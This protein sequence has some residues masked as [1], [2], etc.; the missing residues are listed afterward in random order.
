MSFLRNHK[1]IFIIT[2]IVTLVL[3]CFVA[4]AYHFFMDYHVNTVYVDGSS[5]YSDEE[6]RNMVM[7]GVLGD[8]SMFL[9]LKYMNKSIENVPFV[10]KMSVEILDNNTIRIKVYEKAVA[11]YVE[12]LDNYMYFDKDGVVIE[13]SNEKTK[14]IPLVTGMEFDHVAIRE[15]LP[16]DDASVFESILSITQ[17]VNKYNLSIDR[18]YFSGNGN[19]T[20]FF[21]DIK[22]ALGNS[23]DLDEK[24]M[25]LQYLLPELEG[26]Q[27]TLRMEN[28]TEE[29]KSIS[30]DPDEE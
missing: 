26:K 25:R 18:I 1:S 12:Y 21:D 10:S 11:G 3:C 2:G 24:V 9:S 20:L 8:N 7:D 5:H 22:V 23:G 15:P 17:L 29:T 6:I 4:L 14:G 16:V 13:A 28:Y 27:G 19:I 30:F